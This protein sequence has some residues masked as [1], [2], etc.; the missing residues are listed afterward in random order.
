LSAV[1]YKV[2]RGLPFDYRPGDVM[3]T[4]NRIGSADCI[5][6]EFERSGNAVLVAENATWGNDFAGDRWYTIARNFHNMAD[7]FPVGGTERW[8]ALGVEL[9]PW[10]TEGEIVILPSRG[11]GPREIAMPRGWENQ[12]A[13]RI[14]RHPG[15]RDAVPL[16]ADLAKA[17]RAITWG[18]GAAVKALLW[19]IPVESHMPG[20]IGEQDN[21]D[22]GR[23][24]MFR[25]LAWAQHRL[26]E[27]KSG[28]AFARLLA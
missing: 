4:W 5:A 25:T 15:K 27:I 12:H 13:G 23:L 26:S 10:R 8:D 28:E 7:R 3:V 16:E 24:S 14:R 19:G 9:M 2:K 11:L 18:S 20:W 22:E 17:G 6:R 1:G 21:T